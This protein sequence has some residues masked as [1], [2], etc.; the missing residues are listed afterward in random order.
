MCCLAISYLLFEQKSPDGQRS[1]IRKRSWHR[2]R[3]LKRREKAALRWSPWD[4]THQGAMQM[5][6]SQ[7]PPWGGRGRKRKTHV[8]SPSSCTALRWSEH[9]ERSRAVRTEERGAPRREQSSSARRQVKVRGLACC[10]RVNSLILNGPSLKGLHDLTFAQEEAG[11]FLQTAATWLWQAPSR[12]ERRKVRWWTYTSLWRKRNWGSWPSLRSVWTPSVR[13]ERVP[14]AP[15]PW[16][17]VRDPTLCCGAYPALLWCSS[18]PSSPPSTTA[19]SPGTT[20]SWCTTRSGRSGT[21]SPSAPSSS[22]STPCS[23]CPWRCHWL[24]TLRWCRCPGPLA[25]GGR[26]CETWRKASAAGPA[27]SWAWRT[28][29]PTASWS[30]WTQTRC[31]ALCRARLPVT[32]PRPRLFEAADS[33]MMAHVFMLTSKDFI[34]FQEMHLEDRFKGC[35]LTLKMFCWSSYLT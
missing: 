7:D 35:F 26:P 25:S 32:L 10:V 3:R 24:C 5:M 27:G 15:A 9:P 21:R 28:V 8:R 23:S 11:I 19:H 6:E 33:E 14:D 13:R 17:F 31:P 1:P 30:C 12:V 29:L 2:W 16:A 4:Q 18:F 34:E 22:S 20:S